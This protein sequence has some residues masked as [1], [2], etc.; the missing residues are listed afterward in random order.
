VPSLPITLDHIISI[1]MYLMND[2][3]TGPH[4]DW[5]FGD[6]RGR[7]RFT[8][9]D[10]LRAEHKGQGA[11]EQDAEYLCEGWLD[12]CRGEEGV[13]ESFVEAEAGWSGW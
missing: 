1:C 3:L 4:S 10:A 6:L 2:F 12:E 7:S 13:I 11:R 9:L 8:S 5:L